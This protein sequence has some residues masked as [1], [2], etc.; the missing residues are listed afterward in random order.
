MA[1]FVA[2]RSVDGSRAAADSWADSRSGKILD[3]AA[4]SDRSPLCADP[5]P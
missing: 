2:V 3:F 5:C 1:C 4:F